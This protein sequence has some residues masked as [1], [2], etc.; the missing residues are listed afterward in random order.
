MV[1]TH[2]KIKRTYKDDPTGHGTRRKKRRQTEKKWGDN[3]SEWTGLGLGEPIRKAEDR[4]EWWKVVARSFL[5][6][7]RSL[8]Q[9]DE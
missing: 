9:R 6:S 2:K 8:R 1:W 3:I 7:Q 4:E 5:M